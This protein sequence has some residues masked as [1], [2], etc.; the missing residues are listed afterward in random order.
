MIKVEK[1]I[2]GNLLLDVWCDEEDVKAIFAL[3]CVTAITPAN[4]NYE[5]KKPRWFHVLIDARWETDDAIRQIEALGV[6]IPDTFK[7]AFQDD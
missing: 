6:E 4:I 3:D 2:C 1:A 7:E 5:M